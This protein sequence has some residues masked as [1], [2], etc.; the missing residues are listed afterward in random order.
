MSYHQKAQDFIPNLHKTI[1]N[2]NNEPDRLMRPKFHLLASD[3]VDERVFE[4]HISRLT[5]S[6]KLASWRLDKIICRFEKTEKY[7]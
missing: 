5:T 3:R 6:Q 4:K 7:T 1:L 2:R